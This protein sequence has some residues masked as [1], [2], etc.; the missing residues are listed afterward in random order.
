MSLAQTSSHTAVADMQTCVHGFPGYHSHDSTLLRPD[1][2]PVRRGAAWSIFVC[3]PSPQQGR[4]EIA[5]SVERTNRSPYQLPKVV[6]LS[7]R[8]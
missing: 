3:C 1:S 4:K 6:G 8:Q 2:A 5:A 7:M